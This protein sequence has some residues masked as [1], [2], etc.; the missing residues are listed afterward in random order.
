MQKRYTRTDL[1]GRTRSVKAVL[2][3]LN[4]K[5]GKKGGGREV[6]YSPK[7]GTAL[8][9]WP[10][11]TMFTVKNIKRVQGRVALGT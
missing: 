4:H 7:A 10:V 3:L 6:P 11:R 2:R 1:R 8:L 9:S 5:A